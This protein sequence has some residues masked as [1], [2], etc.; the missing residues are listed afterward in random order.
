MLQFV[1]RLRRGARDCNFGGE[2]DNQIRDAVLNKCKSDY[3]QSKLLETGAEL[4]LD[5]ALQIAD[6]CEK[7]EGQMAALSSK[8][9]DPKLESVNHVSDKK[10]KSR[11]K[12]YNPKTETKGKAEHAHGAEIY[13]RFV[14]LFVF[15]IYNVVLLHQT[16]L[17]EFPDDI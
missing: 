7:V 13:V 5:K 8:G 12:Q 16:T 6:K 15:F 4:T 17:N 9:K 2:K 3:V 11:N 14:V 10:Q 1:T